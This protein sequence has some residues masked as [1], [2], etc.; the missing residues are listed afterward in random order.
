MEIRILTEGTI[1]KKIGEEL[2]TS[3]PSIGIFDPKTSAT[4]L[5]PIC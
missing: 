4:S 1:F 5:V 3:R 2:A